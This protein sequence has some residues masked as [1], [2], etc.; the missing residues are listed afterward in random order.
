MEKLKSKI[1]IYENQDE[2]NFQKKDNYTPFELKTDEV[3]TEGVPMF[4]NETYSKED[5]LNVVKNQHA[6]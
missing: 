4:Q 2:I 5:I 1:L 3:I 6:N